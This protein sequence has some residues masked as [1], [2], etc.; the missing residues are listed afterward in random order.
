MPPN[1]LIIFISGP[2]LMQQDLS[3]CLQY[4]YLMPDTSWRKWG[5]RKGKQ[6]KPK[7][8]QTKPNNQSK[9]NY[10]KTSEN[11]L[12]LYYLTALLYALKKYLL[13]RQPSSLTQAN[14]TAVLAFRK[15][16]IASV[17][18]LGSFLSSPFDHQLKLHSQAKFLSVV[19]IPF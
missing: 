1:N 8:P 16:S 3:Q 5:W 11:L 14:F 10:L 13:L 15:G 2:L 7:K 19:K 9:M 18:L 17:R 4:F 12:W 6:K